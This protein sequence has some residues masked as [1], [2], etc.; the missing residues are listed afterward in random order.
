[1]NLSTGIITTVAGDGTE[2]PSATAAWPQQPKL[3][4]RTALRSIPQET[5]SWETATGSAR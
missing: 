5:C 3:A 4:V 2:V 1:M